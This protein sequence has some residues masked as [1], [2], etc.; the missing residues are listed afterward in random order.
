M[1]RGGTKDGEVDGCHL[2]TIPAHRRANA[3][4]KDA[5]DEQHKKTEQWINALTHRF[6]T[7]GLSL[8]KLVQLS[9]IYLCLTKQGQNTQ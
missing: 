4:A 3:S 6:D 7:V 2:Q 8:K 1:Q 9:K 5:M